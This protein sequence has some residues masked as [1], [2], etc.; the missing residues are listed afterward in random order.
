MR[1]NSIA[2]VL[3]TA[4]LII[5]GTLV[6]A[7]STA[8]AQT[9][10]SNVRIVHALDLTGD[11]VGGTPVSVCIDD[12]LIDADFT[13]GEAIGPVALPPATYD[14]E[15]FGGGAADCTGTP[16]FGAMLDVPSGANLTAMAYWDFA[17]Q[18]PGIA[19]LPD[20]VNCLD[21]G[22][23]RVTARHAAAVGDVDVLADGGV[24]FADLP[25][26]GQD[27]A[28]VP[29]ATYSVA[30]ALPDSTDP[31]IGPVNLPLPAATDTQVYAFGG[32]EGE[33]GVFTIPVALETCAEPTTTTAPAPT[34]TA[35][36]AAT[37]QPAFTG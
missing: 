19:V 15:I 33:P 29:T 28:D 18:E 8:G 35:P 30:V 7:T 20:A 17:G 4:A 3:A 9:D 27:I 21:A 12:D 26:G 10:P 24:L 16:L 13:V 37:V 14:V 11:G 22:N 23:A 32:I 34:T 2:A 25:N 31:V 1:R 5:G 36:P 6:G